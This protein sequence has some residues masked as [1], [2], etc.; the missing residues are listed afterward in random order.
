MGAISLLHHP[1]ISIGITLAVYWFSLRVHS[2]FS[3]AH[4]LV[5]ACGILMIFLW[6]AH[7]PYAT[8]RAGGD[9]ISW[10]LGPATVAL[11]IP[12]YRH[13]YRLRNSLAILALVV[14]VG[15]AVGMTTAGLTAY[16]MGAPRPVI[17]AAIPKSVTTPIAIEVSRQLHGIPAIT[18]AMVIITGI[19]G[20]ITGPLVLRWISVDDDLAIG[21]AIGT[22]SHAIGTASLIRRSE[23]QAS[24]SSWA[25]AV[26]GIFT[27]ILASLISYFFR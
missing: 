2:R 6:K 10:F 26:A 8:Y 1:S 13:G 14:F 9:V 5:V 11:A 20:S 4:P 24:V 18:V 12:M 15:S 19:L 16:L 27:A 7:V 3:W 25:M 21:A 23:L 22:S 17:M